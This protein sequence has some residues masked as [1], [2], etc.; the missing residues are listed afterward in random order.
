M[1]VIGR[2]GCEYAYELTRDFGM[3]DM[4]RLYRV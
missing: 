3:V 2:L 1:C 4:Y